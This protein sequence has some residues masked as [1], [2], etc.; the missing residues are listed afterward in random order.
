MGKYPEVE[1]LGQIVGFFFFLDLFVYFRKRVSV[2]MRDSEG[3]R[4]GAE[5]EA[6]GK[7][8]AKQAVD[9]R[10]QAVTEMVT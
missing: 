8:P 2:L 10:P 5:A 6:E 4:G 7:L 1:L 3:A 9:A